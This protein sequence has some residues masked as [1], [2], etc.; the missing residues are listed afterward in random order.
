[1]KITK[2][3][4]AYFPQEQILAVQNQ[5]AYIPPEADWEDKIPHFPADSLSYYDVTIE[6]QGISTKFHYEHNPADC[7]TRGIPTD[8]NADMWWCGPSFLRDSPENWPNGGM[9]FSTLPVAT[10]EQDQE[11]A[12]LAETLLIR[13]HYRESEHAIGQ[14][15]VDRFNAH[16][17]ELGL[18]RCQARMENAPFTSPFLLV[19][20]HPLTKLV[21]LRAHTSFYHQGVYGTMA[22]LRTRYLIPS[23]YRTVARRGTPDLVYSDNVTIFHAEEDA[24]N[25]LFFEHRSWKKIQEF[26]TIHKITKA[27]GIQLSKLDQI[28]TVVVGIEA[29]INSCPITP[30]R[31]K[32][33]LFHLPPGEDTSDIGFEGH[34]LTEWYKDTTQVLDCFWNIWYSEYL[35]ALAQRHQRRCITHLYPLERSA[36]DD[37]IPKPKA[38]K[39]SSPTR[40]QPP[41]KPDQLTFSH[42]LLTMERPRGAFPLKKSRTTKP[43]TSAVAVQQVLSIFTKKIY[44]PSSSEVTGVQSQHLHV[45]AVTQALTAR[46]SLSQATTY[47]QE[48]TTQ[49]QPTPDVMLTRLWTLHRYAENS[50]ASASLYD[51]HTIVAYYLF[52]AIREPYNGESVGLVRINLQ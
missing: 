14:F 24:L 9:D 48:L 47:L 11:F 51:S 18:I 12:Q 36:Q 32:D 20:S 23:I 4:P 35:S 1:M 13:E 38:K 41:R 17:D 43:T 5:P 22:H 8:A 30:Y 2:A 44:V 33:P 3:F 7:A 6:K 27:I 25:K 16:R 49:G 29:V 52:T 37:Y 42:L 28:H 31:E 40:V 10:S 21:I 46:P 39:S 15:H 26:P 50:V 45:L 19:P 34:R